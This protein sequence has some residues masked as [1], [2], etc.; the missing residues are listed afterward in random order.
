M[1]LAGGGI[2]ALVTL[3]VTWLIVRHNELSAAATGRL[4]AYGLLVAALWLVGPV[5]RFLRSEVV[6]R[7]DA[8]MV[9]GGLFGPV[10][11][12]AIGEIASV[13]EHA[14]TLG[15]SLGYGTVTILGHDARGATLR[16]VRD[17]DGLCRALTATSRAAAPRRR[18][19]A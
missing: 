6:V 14:S 12:A 16:H 10:R 13:V 15:R 7:P 1:A 3:L 2:G 8:I 11:R 18:G 5:A 4:V 17:P 9:T 19:T